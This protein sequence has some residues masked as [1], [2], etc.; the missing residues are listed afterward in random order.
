MQSGPPQYIFS[1]Q[2]MVGKTSMKILIEFL[3]EKY[4]K[5]SHQ[6]VLNLLA[7]ENQEF[8]TKQDPITY[9]SETD[10]SLL[11]FHRYNFAIKIKRESSFI[12]SYYYRVKTAFDDLFCEIEQLKESDLHKACFEETGSSTL[13]FEFDGKANL[14]YQSG[15]FMPNLKNIMEK[16][17]GIDD[18]DFKKDYKLRDIIGDK[19]LDNMIQEKIKG[20]S[21]FYESF[22]FEYKRLMISYYPKSKFLGETHEFEGFFFVITYWE[23]IESLG[24]HTAKITMKETKEDK[25][26]QIKLKKNKGFEETLKKILNFIDKKFNVKTRDIVNKILEKPDINTLSTNIDSNNPFSAEYI[27]DVDK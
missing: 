19:E 27:F 20:S 8:K 17:F 4:I 13:L 9:D 3:E 18:L 5:D 24:I 12:T 26:E 2:H 25:T 7:K 23:F 22:G 14:V 1:L 11:V 10:E 6:K 21:D 15:K 16:P